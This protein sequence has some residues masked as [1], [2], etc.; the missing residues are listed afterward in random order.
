[1]VFFKY[2]F[3]SDRFMYLIA[4]DLIFKILVVGFQ[5]GFFN[6]RYCVLMNAFFKSQ[7]CTLDYFKDN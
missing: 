5:Q 2:G 6:G 7:P 4:G 1:M 3:N